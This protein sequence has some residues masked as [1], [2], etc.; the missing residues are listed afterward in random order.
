MVFEC[1]RKNG[2]LNRDDAIA[3]EIMEMC[4]VYSKLI[5][6]RDLFNL[7]SMSYYGVPIWMIVRKIVVLD[8][9]KLVL[10]PSAK[11]SNVTLS[12]MKQGSFNGDEYVGSASSE[13]S[14]HVNCN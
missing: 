14:N 6:F 10:L 1:M 13:G 11:K 4:N 12:E 5:S 9:K 2:M 7:K 8:W 3:N